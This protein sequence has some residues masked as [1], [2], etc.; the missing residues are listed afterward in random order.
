MLYPAHVS[1]P[2]Y[3]YHALLPQKRLLSQ[4]QMFQKV[5][6][7]GREEVNIFSNNSITFG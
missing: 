3:I 5:Y 2:Y 4:P 6:L 7:P 1:Y